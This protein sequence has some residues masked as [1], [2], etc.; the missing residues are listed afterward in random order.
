[1]ATTTRMHRLA[2]HYFLFI[3]LLFM[4]MMT[5]NTV[6]QATSDTAAAISGETMSRFDLPIKHGAVTKTTLKR[7]YW[8]KNQD[9]LQEPIE[10]TVKMA[11]SD[12][13]ALSS[14]HIVG[15]ITYSA[16][17]D[18]DIPRTP[19]DLY[20]FIGFGSVDSEMTGIG[21]ETKYRERLAN[22]MWSTWVK[23][24][25]FHYF[26]VATGNQDNYARG[27]M[28]F[29]LRVDSHAIYSPSRENKLHERLYLDF[30][31]N[32]IARFVNSSMV[33]IEFDRVIPDSGERIVRGRISW[34]T[35]A[36]NGIVVGPVSLYGCARLSVFDVPSVFVGSPIIGIG[37]KPQTREFEMWTTRWPMEAFVKLDT[38][39]EGN[40]VVG[41]EIHSC[42]F[43]ESHQSHSSPPIAQQ[44]QQ[45]RKIQPSSFPG[46]R[47]RTPRC[48]IG[49]D[50][51]GVCGGHNRTCEHVVHESR[52]G[53]IFYRKMA[54]PVLRGDSEMWWIRRDWEDHEMVSPRSKEDDDQEIKTITEMVSNLSVEATHPE[55]RAR[56]SGDINTR[57]TK[58]TVELT[59][60]FS[61]E[62]S[63]VIARGKKD[64]RNDK[65]GHADR[66]QMEIHV[67]QNCNTEG[68]T[69]QESQQRHD[70]RNWRTTRT[71]SPDGANMHVTLSSNF[72]LDYLYECYRAEKIG[73]ATD[74][75]AQT[76]RPALW[77]S[78]YM[79]LF[80][81]PNGRSGPLL[82]VPIGIG[83][84]KYIDTQTSNP[85][86]HRHSRTIASANGGGSS[87]SGND[88][89]ST[90]QEMLEIRTVSFDGLAN[91]VS[92]GVAQSFWMSDASWII[93]LESRVARLGHEYI[94]LGNARV[95]R[96]NATRTVTS[97]PIDGPLLEFLS[98]T[99]CRMS[100]R[101]DI[102]EQ[103]WS[104]TLRNQRPSAR[105]VRS[106]TSN[107]ISVSTYIEFDVVRV[108]HEYSA[109]GLSMMPV[110][111]K[112]TVM[113]TSRHWV[114]IRLPAKLLTEN[115]RGGT[116]LRVSSSPPPIVSGN[117]V[118]DTNSDSRD[119]HVRILQWDKST[120]EP[121]SRNGEVYHNN[122]IVMRVNI[123][124]RNGEELPC[125]TSILDVKRVRM[126]IPKPGV[127]IAERPK[128]CSILDLSDTT[129]SQ[130]N[131]IP[132]DETSTGDL[133]L[134]SIRN[135]DSLCYDSVE[136]RFGVA[137]ISSYHRISAARFHVDYCISDIMQEKKR[138]MLGNRHRDKS[139]IKQG[140]TVGYMMN[141]QRGAS[142]LARSEIGARLN[143]P[144]EDADNN[145]EFLIDGEASPNTRNAD[146]RRD[147]Y[148]AT[149]TASVT[150]VVICDPSTYY[151]PATGQC[152]PNPWYHLSEYFL[153][154]QW[155]IFV[156]IAGFFVC[157]CLYI[158]SMVKN[159]TLDNQG[160]S[161]STREE[162]RYQ[163]D[164]TSY[165][166]A[167]R[168]GQYQPYALRND[169]GA[170]EGRYVATSGRP[171]TD[172]A[173]ITRP[174]AS[175]QQHHYSSDENV[176][177]YVATFRN[178]LTTSSNIGYSYEV[179]KEKKMS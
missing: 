33:T 142:L 42:V 61:V 29:E 103:T 64:A 84:R 149:K 156:S 133:V 86:D 30:K 22:A 77:A 172:F 55:K 10:K 14:T 58:D 143:G 111:R 112:E 88:D 171:N 2:R 66:Q 110:A 144:D 98:G 147:G 128:D 73:R 176:G 137:K 115:H 37:L 136:I 102:C 141:M 146:G 47:G 122:V 32:G 125:K 36:M 96:D 5:T 132:R 168:H 151:D 129:T 24:G 163:P 70:P 43:P 106:D 51:C 21:F 170:H 31:R 158:S 117:A 95:V 9:H 177:A 71:V 101:E 82:H 4:G 109:D 104:L 18:Q 7:V 19:L 54:S 76:N 113:G 161:L 6:A 52:D 131:D 27:H 108:E 152:R 99:E 167:D 85:L 123:V 20:R 50:A 90:A 65:R 69:H 119:V 16:Y 46:T 116:R 67:T 91:V 127:G 75:E 59:V 139:E 166:L 41:V 38:K 150:V 124:A 97:A 130:N 155:T 164:A 93:L 28:G 3:A 114:V 154:W 169:G 145:D 160:I 8:K 121:V 92:L 89:D 45:Q 1:M 72:T 174:T 80:V 53:N 49:Y 94:R 87:N 12:R 165:S 57:G 159:W 138:M 175:Q 153:A 140:W 135:M 17:A 79:S 78:G 81:A 44:Q 63:R 13:S 157:M 120:G 105:H 100:K 39:D 118:D 83:M 148:S 107:V 23:L 26:V 134:Y 35:R 34:E 60:R 74:E 126:C 178:A 173:T 25:D 62:N 15:P 56:T 40:S 162:F 11:G 179:D 68:T 48:T